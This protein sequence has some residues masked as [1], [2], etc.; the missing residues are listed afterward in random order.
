MEEMALYR[1]LSKYYDIA[2]PRKKYRKEVNFIDAIIKKRKTSGK[3][4]LDVA[5]GTGNHARL[6]VKK[7]YTVT[8]IDINR[9]MLKIARK[10]TPKASF[11][12]GN[13]KT[14]NLRKKFDVVAC[15]FTSINYNLTTRDVV[16]TLKNFK[17]HL[18]DDGVIIVDFSLPGKWA[19]AVA[20]FLNKDVVTL[21]TNRNVGNTTEVLIYWIFRNK[22]ENKIVKDF[23]KIRL[24]SKQEFCDAAKK[25]GLK[26]K[27]YWDFSLR[28]RS[29]ERAIF[30]CS[31]S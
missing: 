25:S 13:M 28:K 23:H 10:K 22:G 16:K 17:K 26:C 2:F 27:V 8:G 9:D 24:Y 29:G 21:H 12:M 6:L 18:K 11:K 5:C 19:D 30:V 1:R 4:I 31:H 3:S 15:M 7:G 14:F 20:S